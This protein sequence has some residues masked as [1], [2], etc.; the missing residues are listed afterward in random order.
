MFSIVMPRPVC[1]N[2]GF[3]VAEVRKS[4]HQFFLLQLYGRFFFS[5]EKHKTEFFLLLTDNHPTL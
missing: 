1:R 2:C 4:I 5:L 3:V